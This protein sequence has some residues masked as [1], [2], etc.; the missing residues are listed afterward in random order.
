MVDFREPLFL[1]VLKRSGRRDRETD[2]EHVGLGV[3]EGPKAIIILL[4]GG[5]K[6][7]QGMGLITDPAKVSV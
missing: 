4:S 5:V 3:G 2:Q 7:S 1:H 6:E